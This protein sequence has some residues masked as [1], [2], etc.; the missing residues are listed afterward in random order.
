MVEDLE[1][2]IKDWSV[3]LL[4]PANRAEISD[5]DNTETTQDTPRPSRTKKIEEVQELDSASMKTTSISP[6]QGGDGKEL[7]EK[8]VEKTQGDKVDPLKNKKGSP[9]KPSSRKK[10]KATMTKM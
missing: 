2:I 10:F 1:E 8:E 7:D 3:D 9:S 4:I 6:E 5:I